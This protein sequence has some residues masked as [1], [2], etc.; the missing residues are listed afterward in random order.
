MLG[1]IGTKQL[2]GSRFHIRCVVRLSFDL[3]YDGR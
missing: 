1:F 2:S 3:Y